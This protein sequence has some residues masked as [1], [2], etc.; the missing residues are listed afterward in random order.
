MKFCSAVLKIIQFRKN[1]LLRKRKF[2][3]RL[4]QN[5]KPLKCERHPFQ[6]KIKISSCGVT[7]KVLNPIS[8]MAKQLLSLLNHPS[9]G[10]LKPLKLLLPGR[11]GSLL[12]LLA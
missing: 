6:D 7:N 11:G 10:Y 8:C 9:H 3:M 2:K 4:K 1:D 12:F 5:D